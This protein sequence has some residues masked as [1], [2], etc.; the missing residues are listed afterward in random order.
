LVQRMKY[1]VLSGAGKEC[2]GIARELPTLIEE[3]ARFV[4]IT[5]LSRV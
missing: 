1:G 5:T 4:P 2:R 3:Q